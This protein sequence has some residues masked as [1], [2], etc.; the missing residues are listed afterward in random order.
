VT[1]LAFSAHLDDAVLLCGGTLA[2]YARSGHQVSIVYMCR[3]KAFRGDE[4]EEDFLRTR[5]GEIRASASL[6]G[7]PVYILGFDE[8][9]IP[10]SLAAKLRIVEVIRQVQPQ[11]V[12]AH[13]P[14]D[15]AED[16]HQTARLA[17]VCLAMAWEP[18]FVTDSPPCRSAM[19]VYHMDSIA[20][21]QFQPEEFVDIGDTIALK[22]KML[23][24]HQTR[25]TPFRGHPVWDVLDWLEVTARYRGVQCGVRY[26]EAFARGQHWGSVVPSR[27]L[28]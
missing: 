27:L 2:K 5:E 1:V 11:V 18:M 24:C 19:A 28:P 4:P 16:H 13:S 26:A 14:T 21:W 25:V 7:A 9:Q 10:D 22:R 20:G 3:G 12:F 17:E 23:E 6:I 15:R 8:F